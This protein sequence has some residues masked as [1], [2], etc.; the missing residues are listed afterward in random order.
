MN[1]ASADSLSGN[2]GM[3]CASV[4]PFRKAFSGALLFQKSVQNFKHSS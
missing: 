4:T 1:N 2:I 3:I